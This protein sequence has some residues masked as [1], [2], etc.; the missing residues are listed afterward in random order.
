MSHERRGDGP[1]P[2]FKKE[3]SSQGREF[4]WKNGE[5][6]RSEVKISAARGGGPG[7]QAINTTSN[8][9]EARW[10]IGDSKTLSDEEKAALRVFAKSRLTKADELIF[11]CQS[12]R[13]QVQNINEVL[14]RLNELVREALTPKTKRIPTKK[15]KSR[16][17]KEERLKKEGKTRKIARGRVTKWDE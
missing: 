7:G 10:V 11:T 4:D 9:M 17:A 8:N 14:N 6:P 16:K 3:R 13:S 1:P 15:S 12:E 5:I 2:E